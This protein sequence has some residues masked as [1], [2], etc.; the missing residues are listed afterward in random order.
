MK[1]YNW[2]EDPVFLAM[3]PHKMQFLERVV[4]SAGT[5]DKKQLV[6][7]FTK[8][9]QEA[10]QQGISFSDAELSLILAAMTP[11]MSPAEKK[12]LQLIQSMMK[13]ALAKQKRS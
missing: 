2:K 11:H 1:D 5:L 12:R 13:A 9:L 10:R 4:A 8:V 3:P 7:Y 6:P